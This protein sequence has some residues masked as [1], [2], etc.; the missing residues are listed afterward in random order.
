METS[1]NVLE[2]LDIN[3]LTVR[4]LRE[5][6]EHEVSLISTEADKILINKFNVWASTCHPIYRRTHL[7]L[8]IFVVPDVI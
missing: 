8:I 3:P 4:D 2:V 5:A 6:K 7:G 1:V